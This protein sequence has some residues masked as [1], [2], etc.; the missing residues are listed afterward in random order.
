[1]SKNNYTEKTD[2][3]N[4]FSLKLEEVGHPRIFGQILGWLLI[5]NPRHQSF[6]DLMENL[7]ISKASVSNITRILLEVGLIERVR[8]T[9]ERQMYFKLKNGALTEFMDKQIKHIIEVKTILD[10][11][12]QLVK[13]NEE[14][15]IARL[16]KASNFYAFLTSELPGLIDR[17]NNLQND[18]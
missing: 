18:H 1:M 11:G 13:D 10:K 15:D 2:F 14:D 4:D 9:G 7:D 3:V 6:T 5:C 8:I 16:E 12:L 17:F